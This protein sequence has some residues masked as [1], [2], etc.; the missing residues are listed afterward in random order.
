LQ[1]LWV[2][3][4]KRGEN[5]N[6]QLPLQHLDLLFESEKKLCFFKHDPSTTLN[7]DMCLSLCIGE[8]NRNK[9]KNVKI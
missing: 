3:I 6:L 9:T 5:C 7:I 4:L 1:D 2:N 8:T